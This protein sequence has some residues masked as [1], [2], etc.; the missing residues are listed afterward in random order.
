MNNVPDWKDI[1]PR[2]GVAYD[3][4]GNGKTA[5]QGERQPLRDPAGLFL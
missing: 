5:H 3:L 4:F 1:D 2:I